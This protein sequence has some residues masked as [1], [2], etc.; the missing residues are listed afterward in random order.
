V[1]TDEWFSGFLS[2]LAAWPVDDWFAPTMGDKSVTCQSVSVDFY[3]CQK[4]LTFCTSR[5]AAPFGAPSFRVDRSAKISGTGLA[6]GL[7]QP[8]AQ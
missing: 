8:K 3:H 4:I 5:A 7:N 2:C 6:L 1:M